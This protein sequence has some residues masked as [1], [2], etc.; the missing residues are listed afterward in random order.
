MSQGI[1]RHAIDLIIL[2]YTGL[3]EDKYQFILDGQHRQGKLSK[4]R[5]SV[6]LRTGII[7][8][9]NSMHQIITI[10]FK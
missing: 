5:L 2:K 7:V 1:S 8:S 10:W 6:V 4:E 9:L 3:I